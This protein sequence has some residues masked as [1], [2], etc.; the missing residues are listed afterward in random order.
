MHFEETLE[1]KSALHVALEI[2]E[3]LTPTGACLSAREKS[4]AAADN[5]P[6]TCNMKIYIKAKCKLET[7]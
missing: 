6:R 7:L 5:K 2:V 1:R 3:T 4:V